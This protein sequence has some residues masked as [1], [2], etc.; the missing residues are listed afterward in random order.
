VVFRHLFLV[1]IALI[2]RGMAVGAGLAIKSLI[3]VL[4]SNLI[5][6]IIILVVFEV[7]ELLVVLAIYRYVKAEEYTLDHSF[8]TDY[9]VELRHHV[10]DVGQVVH[11]H[12]QT[13]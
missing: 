13:D 3:Q 8:M 6:P 12:F 5:L 2:L 10:L 4:I 7:K 11:V 1:A 9:L